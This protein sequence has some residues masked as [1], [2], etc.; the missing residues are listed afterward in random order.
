MGLL[1]Q[2]GENLKIS[3]EAPDY[4]KTKKSK[5]INAFRCVLQNDN[6]REISLKKWVNDEVVPYVNGEKEVLTLK[7]QTS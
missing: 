1:A 4:P 3:C 7:P 5:I 2:N 6:L